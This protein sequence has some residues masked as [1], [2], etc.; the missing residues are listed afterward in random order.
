MAGENNI[1]MAKTAFID[2]EIDGKGK[3]LDICGVKDEQ[4]FHS[5]ILGGFIDFIS[6]CD[7]LCGHNIV[8]HDIK[9]LKPFLKREYVLVDTIYLSPLLF[10][11]KPYH[12]L[13]KDDKILSEELNNPLND[14]L[15]A[16]SLYKDE[17][18]AFNAL[19]HIIDPNHKLQIT[20]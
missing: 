1:L 6:D 13:L 19:D 8:E 7:I 14:S 10:P 9:Y 12:R 16:Q 11:L 15:K 18:R 17:V 4:R 3:I 2:L 20:Y 5:S